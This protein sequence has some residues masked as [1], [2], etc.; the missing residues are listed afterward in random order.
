MRSFLP[1]NSAYTRSAEK[2]GLGLSPQVDVSC[3]EGG[4]HM[5]NKG[6]GSGQGQR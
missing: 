2:P 4:A 6:I 3:A 1:Y 5:R